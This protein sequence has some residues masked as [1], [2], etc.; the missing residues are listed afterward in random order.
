MV[1]IAV[2]VGPPDPR[3]PV[4]VYLVAPL[5][6]PGFSHRLGLLGLVGFGY[7]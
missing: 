1:L 7:A 3:I 2:A 5:S 6:A 4:A